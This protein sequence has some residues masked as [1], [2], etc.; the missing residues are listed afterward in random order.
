MPNSLYLARPEI[1]MFVNFNYYVVMEH[2]NSMTLCPRLW[3][4][5][6][7]LCVIARWRQ[8]CDQNSWTSYFVTG[9]TLEKQLTDLAPQ[10]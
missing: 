5:W 8:G 10:V 7:E 1:L 6:E 9:V 4:G 2:W 3:L